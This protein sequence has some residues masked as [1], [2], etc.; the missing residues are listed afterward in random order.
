[1][2]SKFLQLEDSSRQ[3][4]ASQRLLTNQNARTIQSIL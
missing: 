3:F 2:N 4:R 1:M